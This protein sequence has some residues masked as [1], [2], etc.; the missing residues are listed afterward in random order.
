MPR[1]RKFAE[2]GTCHTL[3][4]ESAE[5]MGGFCQRHAEVQGINPNAYFDRRFCGS[6]DI[7]GKTYGYSFES[8]QKRRYDVREPLIAIVGWRREAERSRISIGRLIFEVFTNQ[9]INPNEHL[10]RH[11]QSVGLLPTVR[12]ED[13][14]S[15]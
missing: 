5:E 13:S 2:L 14:Q 9:R 4:F 10:W 7:S 15:S 6:P 8:M 1:K 12:I 3:T 11:L